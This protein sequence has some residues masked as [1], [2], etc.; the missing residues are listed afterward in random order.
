MAAKS[1]A[2]STVESAAKAANTPAQTLPIFLINGPNLNLLGMRE[3]EIYGRTT[4]ADIE[5]AVGES[6]GELGLSVICRQSNHEGDLVDWI[7]EARTASCGVILNAGAYTHTSVAIHDALRALDKPVIEVHLSNPHA[8][9]PF[10]HQSYI[11]PIASG[12]IAGFGANSYLLAVEAL[13][14]L[15]R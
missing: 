9:E 5:H 4:L 2:K 14:S 15:I 1:K 8:R 3:P 12:V 11:S 6:A 10:R 13:A 7:Q